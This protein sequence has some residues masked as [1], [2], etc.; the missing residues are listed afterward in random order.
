LIISRRYCR[1]YRAVR[2]PALAR[3]Q[4]RRWWWSCRPSSLS[5]TLDAPS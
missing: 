2:L 1:C 3:L 4:V 5:S